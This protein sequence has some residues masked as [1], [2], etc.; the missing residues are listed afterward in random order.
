MGSRLAS[1]LQ[2][3]EPA[4]ANQVTRTYQRLV[5]NSQKLQEGQRIVQK[6]TELRLQ[7]SSIEVPS[8]PLKVII[9]SSTL[10]VGNSA[11]EKIAKTSRTNSSKEI[12]PGT[13]FLTPVL[14]SGLLI[15]PSYI[16]RS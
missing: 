14:L 6:G 3:A 15:G 5:G 16:I 11:L 1:L 8:E 2:T 4:R 12:T 13:Q 10:E 9:V 7:N